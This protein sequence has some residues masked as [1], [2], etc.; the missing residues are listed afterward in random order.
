MRIASVVLVLLLSVVL[1]GCAS[2]GGFS[3]QSW[4]FPIDGKV[5][6]ISRADLAAAITSANADLIYGVHV[7]DRNNVRVDIGDNINEVVDYDERGR[8][9]VKSLRGG[10]LYVPIRRVGGKWESGHAVIAPD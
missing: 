4:K 3:P 6:S 7:I 10:P 5:S 1:F 9:Y 8:S 2:R